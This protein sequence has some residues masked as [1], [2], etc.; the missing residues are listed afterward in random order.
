LP[1]LD[2]PSVLSENKWGRCAT[3][4]AGAQIDHPLF[5]WFWNP[6]EHMALAPGIRAYRQGV[7]YAHGGLSFQECLTLHLRISTGQSSQPSAVRFTDIIWKGLRCTVV[8]EP[9]GSRGD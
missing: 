8:I 2:L 1:K 7:E 5:P 3:I 9:D 6:T 4:K